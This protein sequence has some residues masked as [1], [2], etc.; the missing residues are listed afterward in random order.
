M[1]AMAKR[2]M[3][4]M[5]LKTVQAA[6][7]P[8]WLPTTLPEPSKA[9]SPRL[10]ISEPLPLGTGTSSCPRPCPA[11][12]PSFIFAIPSPVEA[13]KPEAQATQ[14]KH[15]P[16]APTPPPITSLPC[17]HGPPPL[18]STLEAPS[19]GLSQAVQGC[20]CLGWSRMCTS[21]RNVALL[22][23]AFLFPP[24]AVSLGSVCPPA[25][26]REPLH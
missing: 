6:R 21:W 18:I 13:I 12:Q 3:E 24:I 15:G 17:H 22:F 14:A 11:A 1:N 4:T 10:L 25:L 2:A 19:R 23:V 20:S 7:P 8:D 16:A 5:I 26:L 9:G